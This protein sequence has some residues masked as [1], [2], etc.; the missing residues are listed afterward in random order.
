M[1]EN[2]ISCCDNVNR[3]IAL[4]DQLLEDHYGYPDGHLMGIGHTQS[5]DGYLNWES[6]QPNGETTQNCAVLENTAWHD[7]ACDDIYYFMCE[8]TGSSPQVGKYKHCHYYLK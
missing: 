2:M 1:K 5:L 6:G 7:R 8:Y 4:N 3:W